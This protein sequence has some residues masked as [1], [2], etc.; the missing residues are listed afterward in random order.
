MRRI[1][2]LVCAIMLMNICA[3]GEIYAVNY[4][5][6]A[7][8][9]DSSGAAVIPA[10]SYDRLSILTNDSGVLTGYAAGRL[11]EDGLL[12]S[13]LNSLGEPL[14]D[15]EYFKIVSAG[16][17]CI[18]YDNDGC[19]YLS[20]AHKY[21]DQLFSAMK[22]AG[23][24][25]ILAVNGNIYDD[26]GDTLSILW[27]DGISFR[28]GIDML[29]DFGNISEGLM[30]LYDDETKRFGYINNQGSWII[31]PSFV[32]AS[33][34]YNGLAVIAGN[35]G[36]GIIDRTGEIK[37]APNS[38]QLYRSGDIFASL[39][40][41]SLRIY[42][43][44]LTV[45]AILPLSGAQISLTGNS[46]VLTSADSVTVYDVYGTLLFSLPDNAQVTD[47]GNGTFIVR[48]GT[49][50]ERS[51]YLAWLDG[52]VLSI[53][54]NS[55]YSLDSN[56]L[57]YALDADDENIYYGLMSADGACVTEAIYLSM[58]CVTDGMYCAD[59]ETGAVL[60]NTEGE[61]LNTFKADR[62]EAQN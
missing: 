12:Y 18:V 17:G 39:R 7:V 32:Y 28:T 42:D 45:T 14:T 3:H 13:V 23:S 29:G 25:M 34:F 41:D 10:G 58:A 21:D 52:S 30:P 54:C 56:C 37:L 48:N 57:A 26:I 1:L 20:A 51:A 47:A 50:S 61:I 19:R 36:Y 6:G 55:I 43:S 33:D 16:E 44:E 46:I 49:W 60:L 22:Y 27:A 15:H 59:T 2:L 9:V 11:T 31:R 40:S 5:G 35:D 8:A 53:P 38:R 62:T 4:N 24:G